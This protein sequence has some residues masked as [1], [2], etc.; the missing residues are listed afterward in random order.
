M[1]RQPRRGGR[2][3][4]PER[5]N[6]RTPD[7]ANRQPRNVE[8]MIPRNVETPTVRTGGRPAPPLGGRAA[9]PTVRT[10][11]RPAPDRGNL[12]ASAAP[13]AAICGC[14]FPRG[15]DDAGKLIRPVHIKNQTPIVSE[16]QP[17]PDGVPPHY[18]LD[19]L[20][21]MIRGCGIHAGHGRRGLLDAPCAEVA[22]CLDD[23]AG[24]LRCALV[25]RKRGRPERGNQRKPRPAKPAAPPTVA[26]C[27]LR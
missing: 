20:D 13:A 17:L 22:G 16:P 15:P 24:I 11:G 23:H 7:R 8:T 10:G 1:T 4:R 9:A 5:G 27:N 18:R 19:A 2:S 14:G 6:Q 12:E 21:G 26:T 25:E 3:R